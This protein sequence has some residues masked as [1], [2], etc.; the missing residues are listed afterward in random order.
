MENFKRFTVEMLN[1]HRLDSLR[2]MLYEFE[3]LIRCS[4]TEAIYVIVLRRAPRRY[5]SERWFHGAHQSL[6]RDIMLS[7]ANLGLKAMDQS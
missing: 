6:L 1:F 3:Q 7:K 5:S 4:L 2:Y